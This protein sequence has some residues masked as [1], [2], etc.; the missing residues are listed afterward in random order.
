VVWDTYRNRFVHSSNTYHVQWVTLSS[1]I[2]LPETCIGKITLLQTLPALSE[3]TLF[4][5][6]FT[7]VALLILAAFSWS[8]ALRYQVRKKTAELQ[9]ELVTRVRT[10]QE[11]RT[12]RNYLNNIIDT[13]AEP[14]FVK[15]R[16]HRWVILND[17]VCRMIG[18]PR[19][20]LLGKTD[21]DIFPPSEAEVFHQRDE[22]VF[23]TGT[24][25]TN[26]EFLTDASG[27]THTILTKKTLYTDSQGNP[28]IV[29]IIL[30]ITERKRFDEETK[31]FHEDLEKRVQER[32][33]EL[34]VSNREL[35][36]F[37]YTVSHDLRAPLRA[38]DGFS[39]IVLSEAESSLTKENVH[40]LLQ[41]RKNTQQM[42]MLIDDLL[43]YS[44]VGKLVLNRQWIY[45]ATIV[46]DVLKELES[47]KKDR[48]VRIN[49]D[50]LPPLY[51][52]AGMLHQV[53]Y[54]LLSNA[55]KFSRLRP[56]TEI[57]IGANV[58]DGTWVYFVRDNGIGFDMQY[59]DQLFGVFHRLHHLAEYEGTGVGL[60]IVHRIIQRHN[61]SIWANSEEGKGATFYFTM[62]MGDQH[63]S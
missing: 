8:W 56:Y 22:I 36:S 63:A 4:F 26:E 34:E 58:K 41:V 6:L 50:Y 19:E 5:Y 33:Q 48:D 21:Y 62:D 25:D 2:P 46:V 37:T 35:E 57:E 1:L 42:A 53:Y 60:A 17:A 28:Y 10:E 14:V 9:E 12:A 23:K 51:A 38:I 55:L 20:E 27:N 11:L 54:N 61:G 44:R 39:S 3:Q 16:Q 43:N 40:M 52:D 15:D 45:P 47:E 49:V 18:H 31:R 13:I 7:P 29:G 32:T 59:Q 30:D 24:A